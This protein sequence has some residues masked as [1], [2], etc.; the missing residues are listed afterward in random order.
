MV[1]DSP[2]HLPPLL[3]TPYNHRPTTAPPP[4]C[5]YHL[6]L[7]HRPLFLSSSLYDSLKTTTTTTPP[8][9]LHLSAS[10]LHH[11]RKTPTTAFISL[12]PSLTFFRSVW[13][14]CLRN[15]NHF[16]FDFAILNRLVTCFYLQKH[17]HTGV[18]LVEVYQS[19]VFKNV[20]HES[21]VFVTLLLNRFF[22]G[23][24]NM[25]S[26]KRMICTFLYIYGYKDI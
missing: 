20:H 8:L 1:L 2:H 22:I 7:N 25:G 21:G 3:Q 9:P 6:S 4:Q 26:N 12:L 24:P 10:Q 11:H 13:I 5:Y 16:L 19:I 17:H 23:F 18:T 15:S 14:P